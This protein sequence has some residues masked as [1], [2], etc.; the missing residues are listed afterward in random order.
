MGVASCI[1]LTIFRPGLRRGVALRATC[2]KKITFWCP[3]P[4]FLYANIPEGDTGFVGARA[5]RTGRDKDHE[6]RRSR[7]E[8]RRL[9]RRI[10]RGLGKWPIDVRHEEG[11]TTGEKTAENS[12]LEAQG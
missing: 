4:P 1:L 6:P 11:E 8:Q 5:I 7:R 10:L 3:A 2:G 9:W 12:S